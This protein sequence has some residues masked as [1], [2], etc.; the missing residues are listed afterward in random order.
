MSKK[1]SKAEY[2]DE[3]CI[4]DL[5]KWIVFKILLVVT[6]PNLAGMLGAVVTAHQMPVLGQPA[7]W[8]VLDISFLSVCLIDAYAIFCISPMRFFKGFV[9]I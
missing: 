4:L 2:G 1:D 8:V 3:I 7:P 9:P 6:S 5:L